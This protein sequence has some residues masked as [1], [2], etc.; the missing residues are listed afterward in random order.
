MPVFNRC[1]GTLAIIFALTL[2]LSPGFQLPVTDMQLEDVAPFNIKAKKDYLIEDA[3][4]TQKNKALA[5]ESTLP[6]Y[7]FDIKPVEAH[8]SPIQK[9]FQHMGKFY[10]SKISNI[11][12][13][14]QEAQAILE[15]PE[16]EYS[17]ETKSEK[18]ILKRELDEAARNLRS[19]SAFEDAEK[20]FLG[21]SGLKLDS[22][23]LKTFRWHHYNPYI[24]NGINGLILHVYKNGIVGDREL[25]KSYAKHGITVRDIDTGK[26]HNLKKID[27]IV[28][29]KELHAYLK[30]NVSSFID[31]AHTSLQRV[32]VKI[33]AQL[34]HPN[35]TFN[36]QETELRREKR[37]E[38]VKS[39][40]FNIKKG[41][42]IVRE[43]ERIGESQLQKLI[44]MNKES[45]IQD[46]ILSLLGFFLFFSLLFGLAWYYLVKYRPDVVASGRTLVLLGSILLANFL[47]IRMFSHFALP[48]AVYLDVPVETVYYAIPFAAAPMLAALLFDLDIGILL[49]VLSFALVGTHLEWKFAYSLV[50]LIGGLFAVLRK[51][52]YKQRSSILKNGAFIGLLNMGMIIPLDLV[53]HTLVSPKG[54]LDLQAGF[55][56]GIMVTLVV[57]WLL[58]IFE[59][60][61]HVTS[62]IKLQEIS[63]LNHPL[64]REMIVE[65]PGTYHHSIVVSTLA[66]GAAEA[67][68]ANPLVVR[69][70]AYY[71]DI[72]KMKKPHYY[73][74]N[75]KGEKNLH[76]KIAPSMSALIVQSH[77]KEGLELAKAHKL[78]PLIVNFIKEHHGTTLMKFFFGKAKEQEKPGLGSVEETPYR[79][80][81][82][83][84]Q[85][86]ETAI[87]LLAD[88]IEAASRSLQE[89]TH[90]RL[91]GLV[92]KLINDKLV[93]GELDECD[94]TLKDLNE[95]GKVFVGI[96][97][98][99]YH[100]RI[101][102]PDEKELKEKKE[103]GAIGNRSAHSPEK[104]E[105]PT[106]EVKVRGPENIRKLELSG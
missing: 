28:S 54:L 20:E 27:K 4:S 31:P 53:Q 71:H 72:G 102:Y 9:G 30:K 87:V 36:K 19:S 23:I 16:E 5:R 44:G 42:M 93:E 83:K 106:K 17:N 84:P 12:S 81:G 103:E 10:T 73:I 79:Y 40:F 85:S 75:Q 24:V 52:Y 58:P 74:E 39:V 7:D 29:M 86:K 46:Y 21:I 33:V 80:V 49:V 1:L 45:N 69:V 18:R 70:G 51:N 100:S 34:A 88:T 41:E 25:F 57:S 64:L 22:K 97:K 37:E 3:I 96:L 89:P 94:L 2:I 63:N 47:I 90:S 101:E 48:I 60:I 50:A 13:E 6:V 61:F 55:I 66:E 76:D 11:Y 62:D 43:G 8:S 56:G 98:G 38:A 104:G 65:A 15:A 35:L 92:E 14:L 91:Q 59:S 68:G 32:V 67:V 82:P 26:E 95:I 77:V 78:N 105:G 99:I